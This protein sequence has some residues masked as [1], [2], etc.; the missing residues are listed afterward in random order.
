MLAIS[1]YK[2]FAISAPHFLAPP[3]VSAPLKT[4]KFYKRPGRLLE[5]LPYGNKIKSIDSEKFTKDYG[6]R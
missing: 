2:C 1:Q 6:L 4:P 3:L 5:D